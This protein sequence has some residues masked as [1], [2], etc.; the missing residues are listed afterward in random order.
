MIVVQSIDELVASLPRI[1]SRKHIISIDG[2]DGVGKTYAGILI[3]KSIRAKFLD[4][5]S[6]LLR[7][8]GEYF[9]KIK[10]HEL[11]Q[12]I[13]NSSRS[14]VCSGV[15]CNK[16]FSKIEIHQDIKIYIK[17][18]R[19]GW[20]IN[21]FE[22]GGNANSIDLEGAEMEIYNSLDIEIILYHRDFKPVDLADIVFENSFSR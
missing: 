14:V 13:N 15:M 19:N 21:C 10:F 9:E 4:F 7:H 2:A 5:D 6:F 17:N 20:W 18:I 3:A 16:V 8:Q 11:K 22:Y 12:V 1:D